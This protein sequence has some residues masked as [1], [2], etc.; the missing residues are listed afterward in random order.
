MAPH[1]V[2]TRVAFRFP[3][4]AVEM[5]SCWHLRCFAKVGG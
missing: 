2:E 1:D 4:Q 5:K 3:F